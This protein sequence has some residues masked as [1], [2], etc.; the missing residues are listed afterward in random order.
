MKVCKKEMRQFRK[1]DN[2]QKAF[3]SALKMDG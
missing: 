3:L 1:G 2:T